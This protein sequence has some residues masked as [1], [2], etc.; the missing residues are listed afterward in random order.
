MADVNR[1]NMFEVLKKLA[2]GVAFSHRDKNHLN[3]HEIL[4]KLAEEIVSY[5]ESSTI[6]NQTDFPIQWAENRKVLSKL[7]ELVAA[8]I[9]RERLIFTRSSEYQE[10]Q[11]S[12]KIGRSMRFQDRRFFDFRGKSIPDCSEFS[13]ID[14]SGANLHGTHT[15]RTRMLYA[16]LIGANLSNIW[17]RVRLTGA[18]LSHAN[19]QC[20]RLSYDLNITNFSN[21]NLSNADLSCAN[22]IGTDFT[23]ANLSNADLEC[24]NLVGTVFTNANVT[25]TR[26]FRQSGIHP[27][28][29]Q[30]LIARGAIFH[31]S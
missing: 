16:K 14:F 7:Q 27:T 10:L 12:Q 30:D 20:A 28:L 25:N 13:F 1:E 9:E 2:R 11:N 29:K 24:T 26:F 31:E 3:I 8:E 22:L 21:A 4:E 18:D 17:W 23:N 5:H 6:Y 15:N 19:L